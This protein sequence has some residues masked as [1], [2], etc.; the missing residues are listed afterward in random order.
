MLKIEKEP[1]FWAEVLVQTP[2]DD[3]HRED[4][5]RVRFK[6]QSAEMVEKYD[7]RFGSPDLKDF[8]KA[9]V[10]DLTDIEDE[11]ANALPYN[12]ELLDTLL[13][14]YGARLAMWNTYITAVTK[15]RSG[16]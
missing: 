7:T 9:T 10:V 6:V 1:K 4:S 16:N 11:N 5:F 15:A 8:L 14:N 3:G 2:V 12:D 13:G